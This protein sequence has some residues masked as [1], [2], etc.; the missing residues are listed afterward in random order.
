MMTTATRTTISKS[1][2][3]IHVSKLRLKSIVLDIHFKI[4]F[5]VL[6]QNILTVPKIHHTVINQSAA[7]AGVLLSTGFHKRLFI[8]FSELLLP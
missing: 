3:N 8:T 7:G 5:V 2:K 4:C 1:T 6:K